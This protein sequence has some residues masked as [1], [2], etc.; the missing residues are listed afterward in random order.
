MAVECEK[1]SRG[2]VAWVLFACPLFGVGI[3]LDAGLTGWIPVNLAFL[4]LLFGVPAVLTVLTSALA[5]LSVDATF[6]LGDRVGGHRR[7]L[8][9]NDRRLDAQRHAELG[10]HAPSKFP[11]EAVPLAACA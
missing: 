3:A 8:A 11:V 10:S 9:S 5:H 2:V 4:A 1:S 6:A 7:R